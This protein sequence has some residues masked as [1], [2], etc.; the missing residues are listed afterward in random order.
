MGGTRE[1]RETSKWLR[2]QK[3]FRFESSLSSSRPPCHQDRSECFWTPT[4]IGERADHNPFSLLFFYFRSKSVG[5]PARQPP[6]S[7]PPPLPAIPFRSNLPRLP[8]EL[9]LEIVSRVQRLR[10]VASMQ[11]VSRSFKEL[12]QP[13]RALFSISHKGV[14]SLLS[15]FP[16][17]SQTLLHLPPHHDE[18]YDSAL[19]VHR[20]SFN[21]RGDQV[22]S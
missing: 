19:S 5:K 3:W 4:P 9:L 17:H 16:L 18:I 1:G 6:D 7:F 21:G 12:S 11:L 10:D 22:G 13:G 8:N 20:G 14:T 15:S 2:A